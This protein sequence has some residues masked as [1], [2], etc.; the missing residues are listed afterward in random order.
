MDQDA[1]N[2]EIEAS[3]SRFEIPECTPDK[4]AGFVEFC[5]SVARA[6]KDHVAAHAHIKKSQAWH[7]QNNFAHMS[8]TLR[9]IDR[10]Y[11]VKK[12]IDQHT[13][14]IVPPDLMSFPD[15]SSSCW[16]EIRETIT[17][18]ARKARVDLNVRESRR[19]RSIKLK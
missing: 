5:N 3:L 4:L 9:N 8:V 15:A 16:N 1:I 7:G 12:A 19:R 2:Q 18:V 17:T 14:D 10:Y 13:N 6:Q 11:A